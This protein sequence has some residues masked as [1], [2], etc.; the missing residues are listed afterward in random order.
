MLWPFVLPVEITF[1]CFVAFIAIATLAAPALKWKRPR[2]FLTAVSVAVVAF[3]PSCAGIKTILDARR[4]GLFEYAALADV[5]DARVERYLPPA[6]T[7]ITIEK[8]P[9]GYRARFSIAEDDLAAFLDE[10]WTRYGKGRDER[11]GA[12]IDTSRRG[13]E[14]H[15]LH[16]GDLGWPPLEDTVEYRGPIAD[17]GAG[18]W[19][20]YSPKQGM[21]YQ[22]AGYW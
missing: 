21:A 9:M 4:F 3:I 5:R 14:L 17:N 20:W 15:D 10:H 6:A 19:L 1:W 7:A 16:F 18:F 13:R 12:T 11:G 22:Y 2:A 8:Q